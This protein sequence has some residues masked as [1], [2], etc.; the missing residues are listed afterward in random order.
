MT[1]TEFEIKALF[2]K[3]GND[4][5]NGYKSIFNA[6]IIL[7]GVSLIGLSQ[8]IPKIIEYD[9]KAKEI[10]F[11]IQAQEN[12]LFKDVQCNKIDKKIA[13]CNFAKYIEET[14]K[15]STFFVGSIS[16]NSFMFGF[17]LLILSAV[18]YIN[19]AIHAAKK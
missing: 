4:V 17:L 11:S 5:T 18:G 3:I 16:G 14:N 2:K 9:Y 19:N 1:K 13:E 12:K 10:L 8:S 6:S 7:I 15:A